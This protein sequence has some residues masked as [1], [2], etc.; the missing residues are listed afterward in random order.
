[1]EGEAGEI[2]RN[3]KER[4]GL[5]LGKKAKVIREDFEEELSAK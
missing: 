5:T 2:G 4:K 1:M 3:R